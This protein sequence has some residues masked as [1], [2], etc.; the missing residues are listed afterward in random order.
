MIFGEQA[1]KARGGDVLIRTRVDEY[2]LYVCDLIT[3]KQ[4]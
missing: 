4:M 3:V 2:I 1:S